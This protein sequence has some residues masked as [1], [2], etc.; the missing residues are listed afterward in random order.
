MKPIDECILRSGQLPCN[1]P[2]CGQGNVG[3]SMVVATN[4]VFLDTLYKYRSSD[5][6]GLE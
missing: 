6:F 3:G 5:I 4:I 2:H 1:S